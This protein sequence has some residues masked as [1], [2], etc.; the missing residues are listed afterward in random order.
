M[1]CS[2]PLPCNVE[3]CCRTEGSYVAVA[4]L[5]F[6]QILSWNTV[7]VCHGEGKGQE[8][9]WRTTC[10][11][12]LIYHLQ[13]CACVVQTINKHHHV[14]DVFV[15]CMWLRFS[16]RRRTWSVAEP[17]ANMFRCVC[18][19]L[20]FS[21]QQRT[22][23]VAELVANVFLS[24]YSTCSCTSKALGTRPRQKHYAHRYI[25][26]YNTIYNMIP[27]SYRIRRRTNKRC[28]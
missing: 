15:W 18:M 21:L 4:G 23:P 3:G 2:N 14:R 7:W 17:V 25:Q 24:V 16:L 28:I 19:W 11:Q 9:K 20:R 22:W 27:L 5:R 13:I 1:F 12:G 8:G 26:S 6:E 10:K